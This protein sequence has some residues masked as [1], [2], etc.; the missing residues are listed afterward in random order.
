MDMKI[1]DLVDPAALDRMTLVEHLEYLSNLDAAQD[2]VVEN[3]AITARMLPIVGARLRDLLEPI[4]DRWVV[5]I[6]ALSVTLRRR[7]PVQVVADRVAVI[8]PQLLVK[9]DE[10]GVPNLFERKLAVADTR[11]LD[12]NDHAAVA[13]RCEVAD[14]GGPNESI[15]DLD[16][17]MDL[18]RYG[19]ER[20]L[21]NV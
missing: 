13:A 3:A 16:T 5:D 9:I 7:E 12:I 20:F 6:D 1:V 21:G 4:N 10:F 18:F 17:F 15:D 8:H 19:L 11:D 14:I 2:E